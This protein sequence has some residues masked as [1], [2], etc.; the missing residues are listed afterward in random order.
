MD[1]NNKLSSA[2]G[3]FTN[4]DAYLLVRERIRKDSLPETVRQGTPIDVIGTMAWLQDASGARS[5]IWQDGDI[6][7]QLTANQL[8]EDELARVARSM[9]P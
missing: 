3:R 2:Y 8:S 4:G 9:S 1:T 5:L 6:A 7:V